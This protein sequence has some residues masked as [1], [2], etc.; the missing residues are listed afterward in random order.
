L[1]EPRPSGWFYRLSPRLV[2]RTG[3]HPQGDNPV[4]RVL[5]VESGEAFPP[6]H[7][8]TRLCLDLLKEALAAGPANRVL[9]V[10]CGSGVL[11]LA[12]AALGVPRVVGLDIS[13]PAAR[14]TLRN[15]R[16]NGLAGAITAVQGDTECLKASFELVAAN[17]PWEVQMER[18]AE[19]DRLAA[20]GGRLILS[21]FRDNQESLLLKSYLGRGWRLR[22]RVA[23][24]FYHPE[25][26]A[27]MSF[28]WAGWLLEK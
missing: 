11:G 4:E 25:L 1:K 10:G 8:T 16:E 13:G 5:L 9:D 24:E 17:L 20:S 26:P 23:K 14:A 3:R 28:G 2:L 21:G 7:P 15:A 12:A 19:L 18:A 6:G 22:Q 27:D